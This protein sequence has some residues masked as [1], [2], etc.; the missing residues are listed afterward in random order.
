M[1]SVWGKNIVYSL[2]GESHGRGVGL[3]LHGLKSG[4]KIEED[5]I[6]KELLRRRAAFRLDSARRDEDKVI[7]LSGVKDGYTTGAPVTLFL[8]NTDIRSEDYEDFFD[9]PRPSHSD[10]VNRIQNGA[11]ADM[12]GGG[13]FSGRLSVPL[14][15]AAAMLKGEFR[16]R[17]VE[18]IYHIS[19]IAGIIDE[20]HL[21]KLSYDEILKLSDEIGDKVKDKAVPMLDLDMSTKAKT[22]IEGLKREGDSIGA[23]CEIAVTGLGAGLG[24]PFF[25]G[26]ESVISSMLFSI[27]GVK[28]VEFGLGSNFAREKGSEVNDEFYYQEGK[29]G[30]KKMLT[31]SNN[32]GGINGGISNGMPLIVAATFKPTPSIAKVQSS[33]SLKKGENVS[34]AIPGRHDACIALKGIRAMDAALRLAIAEYLL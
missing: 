16:T 17:G 25:E 27:P 24:E 7:F 15:A 1:K 20:P 5:E 2:F 10:Y 9:I 28:A 14:I 19:E 32:G 22:L 21:Y 30:I 6:N 33:V 4:I 23:K 31:V 8:E 3:T 18:T 12:R 29:D 34:I 11:H 13:H 26:L